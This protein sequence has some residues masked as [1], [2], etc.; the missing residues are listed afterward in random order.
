MLTSKLPAPKAWHFQD[1]AIQKIT[2]L[3][4]IYLNFSDFFVLLF[5]PS[6][7]PMKIWSEGK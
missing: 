6:L 4:L 5:N 3:E 7:A 1:V 2:E